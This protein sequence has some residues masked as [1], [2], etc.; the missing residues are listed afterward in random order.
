MCTPVHTEC[1]LATASFSGQVALFWKDA[2]ERA[3]SSCKRRRRKRSGILS[4]AVMVF[5]G[6]LRILRTLLIVLVWLCRISRKKVH[7]AQLCSGAWEAKGRERERE[8]GG[9]K[10]RERVSQE[11]KSK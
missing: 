1:T 8:K 10:E 9:K 3:K 4:S 11:R 7:L 6:L 2:C 5:D